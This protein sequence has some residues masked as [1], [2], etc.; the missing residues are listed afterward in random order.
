MLDPA[1][2]AGGHMSEQT[3][4]QTKT[5]QALCSTGD[6]KPMNRFIAALRFAN[7]YLSEVMTAAVWVELVWIAYLATP[8]SPA[9]QLCGALGK[10][11]NN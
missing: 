1:T 4:G 3:R 8:A 11:L 2:K 6:V 5:R 9:S 10:L 7:N